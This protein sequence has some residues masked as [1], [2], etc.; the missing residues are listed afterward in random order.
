MKKTALCVAGVMLFAFLSTP[1]AN[2]AGRKANVTVHNNSEFAI[3]NFFVS[4]TEQESWGPDQL[5]DDVIGNGGKFTLMQIP[6]DTYDV[7]LVDEDGDECVV[8]E[9]DICGGDDDW[10]ITDED[11]LDC[12]GYDTE[13]EE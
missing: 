1:S 9:V 11:L 2:A 7:K 8:P 13:G 5:G 4:P 10:V 6:C 12:E 3:H